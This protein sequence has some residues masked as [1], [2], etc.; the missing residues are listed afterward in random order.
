LKCLHAALELTRLHITANEDNNSD[1][2]DN[3]G[4]E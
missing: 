3:I 1:E 2:D 4:E